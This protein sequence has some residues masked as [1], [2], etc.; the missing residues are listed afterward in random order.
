MIFTNHPIFGVKTRDILPQIAR[1]LKIRAICISKLYR[2]LEI[3]RFF[4]N[5][6]IFREFVDFSRIFRFF[7]NLSIFREFSDF[8]EKLK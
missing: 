8:V 6:P 5:L 3:C 4:A 7:A 2:K 1:L